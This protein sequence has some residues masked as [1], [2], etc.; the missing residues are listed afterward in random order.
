MQ[1]RAK[2]LIMAA[3]IIMTSFYNPNYSTIK[4]CLKVYDKQTNE[5]IS[6]AKIVLDMIY[7]TKKCLPKGAIPIEEYS[8]RLKFKT[9]EKEFIYAVKNFPKKYKIEVLHRKY[10]TVSKTVILDECQIETFINIALEKRE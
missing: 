4:V 3:W 2:V 5:I 8:N 6:N 9:H 7:E 10:K 1:I